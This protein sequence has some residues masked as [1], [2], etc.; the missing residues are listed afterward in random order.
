MQLTKAEKLGEY[1]YEMDT[2]ADHLE[3]LANKTWS[4]MPLLPIGAFLAANIEGFFYQNHH[5]NESR[6]TFTLPGFNC[7]ITKP[8]LLYKNL[9]IRQ[10]FT[11]PRF[12]CCWMH[13]FV[14][15][16]QENE[17]QTTHC[18]ECSTLE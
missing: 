6:Q 12:N 2:A 11:L 10:T 1:P 13:L 16:C 15:S 4:K 3:S 18:S 7:L 9:E 5:Q 8:L 14:S 17:N